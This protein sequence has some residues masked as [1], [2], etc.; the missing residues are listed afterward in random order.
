MGK[1]TASEDLQAKADEF[2]DQFGISA[3]QA[4][5]NA[6]T[7]DERIEALKASNGEHYRLHRRGAR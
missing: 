6:P 5:A 4:E 7:R 3:Q 1:H 2:D